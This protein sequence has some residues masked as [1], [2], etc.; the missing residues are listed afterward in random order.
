MKLLFFTD[1]HMAERP[2]TA[3]TDEYAD[4]LFAKLNE[5]RQIAQVEDVDLTIF[6]G[7]MFHWMKPNETSHRLVQLMIDALRDW[8]IVGILGNHCVGPDG[9]ESLRRQPVGVLERALPTFEL[10]TGD[11][12]K[13]EN[14]GLVI[15]LSAAPWT[16]DIDVGDRSEYGLQRMGGVDF[17]VKITHGMLMPPGG[18][19]PF[20]ATAFD[21]ID[22]EG[23][24]V[25]LCGHTHWRVGPM[26]V[27]GTLFVSPG[28]VARTSRSEANRNPSVAI[29]TLERDCAPVAEYH[30]LKSARAGPDVFTPEV[31]EGAPVGAAFEG[32]VAALE[33]GMDELSVEAAMATLSEGADPTVTKRTWQYL[34]EAGLE[35]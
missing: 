26:V 11:R 4:N 12:L 9:L 20:D 32:Y 10:L 7:D 8:E 29:V 33:Q 5:I 28:A 1:L 13:G 15:Q 2:P 18:G 19:W 16:P 24:D 22:T 3:R 25:C 6:G 21:E 30:E 31:S 23:M 35:R 34:E 17:A 14:G 27:K